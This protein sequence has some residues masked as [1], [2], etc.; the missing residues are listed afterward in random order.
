MNDSV[1]KKL[2]E[3]LKHRAN[4]KAAKE[5][6]ATQKHNEEKASD[7]A[8]LSSLATRV[9]EEVD[10]FNLHAQGLPP[11]TLSRDNDAS[12]YDLRSVKHLTF[13]VHANRLQITIVPSHS[14]LFSTVTHDANGYIYHHIGPNGMATNRLSTEDEIVDSLLRQ[15]CGL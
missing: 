15:A 3:E 12:P 13:S 8:A 11:L 1:G 6:A 10:I 4:E 2:A 5:D 7:D 14:P 9:R